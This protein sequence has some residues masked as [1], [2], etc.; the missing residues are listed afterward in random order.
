MTNQLR[1]EYLRNNGIDI[2]IT[3]VVSVIGQVKHTG[4]YRYLVTEWNEN[5]VLV[6]NHYNDYQFDSY[7]DA[8]NYAINIANDILKNKQ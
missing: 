3:P 8:E 7:N 2:E 5:K 1:R 4:K 6:K